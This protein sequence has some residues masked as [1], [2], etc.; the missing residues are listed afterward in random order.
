[1]LS[2]LPALL[3]LLLLLLPPLYSRVYSDVDHGQ[4]QP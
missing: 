3:L 1:M 2:Y 4:I